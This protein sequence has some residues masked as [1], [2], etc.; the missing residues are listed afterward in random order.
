MCT[1]YIYMGAGKGP[2][3]AFS[4]KEGGMGDFMNN[5]HLLNIYYRTGTVQSAAHE[6]FSSSP[7]S[8][9]RKL[10]FRE[11]LNPAATVKYPLPG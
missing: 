8:Y 6:F 4:Q 3:L 2:M 5:C 1:D 10:K 11:A 7:Q 9:K